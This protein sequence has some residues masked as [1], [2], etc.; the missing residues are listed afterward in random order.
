MMQHEIFMILEYM[1]MY[2]VLRMKYFMKV[3][4]ILLPFK[5]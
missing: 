4:S 2:I 1:Y 3:H 5:T